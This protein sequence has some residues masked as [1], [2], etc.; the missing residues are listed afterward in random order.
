MIFRLISSIT[1]IFVA[2]AYDNDLQQ[3]SLFRAATVQSKEGKNQPLKSVSNERQYDHV[4]V[5]TREKLT[6]SR[7]VQDP[8]D[9]YFCG[10]GFADASSNCEHPCPGG[11]ASE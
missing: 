2:F 10:I 7:R 11:S 1:T 6:A 3:K 5:D 9:H 8:S 4:H